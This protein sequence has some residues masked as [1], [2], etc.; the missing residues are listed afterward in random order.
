MVRAARAAAARPVA[1]VGVGSAVSVGHLGGRVQRQHRK[2][3]QVYA[4]R[5][6]EEEAQP[7]LR[8]VDAAEDDPSH[9]P[10]PKVAHEPRERGSFVGASAGHAALSD[11]M[12]VS[13]VR[14]E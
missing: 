9:D 1:F 14:A 6:P 8:V 7:A 10:D 2:G 3:Q 13:T 5:D 4:I 12:N 11:C